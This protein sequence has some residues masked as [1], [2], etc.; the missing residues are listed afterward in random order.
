VIKIAPFEFTASPRRG[1]EE[2]APKG[3]ERRGVAVPPRSDESAGDNSIDL[4]GT[5]YFNNYENSML[6]IGLNLRP[7]KP[8]INRIFGNEC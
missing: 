8:Q 6:K 3:E 5:K 4:N 2:H 1:E 7:L